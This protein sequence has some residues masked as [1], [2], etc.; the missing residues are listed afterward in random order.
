ML[1]PVF[2]AYTGMHTEFGLLSTLEDWL[3]CGLTVLVA[4]AGK[5][6]GTFVTA[7]LASVTTR[8]AASLG[9]LMNTSGLVELV[10]VMALITTIATTPILDFIHSRHS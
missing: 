6:G 5:F 4:A 2:F 10:V 7:K 1:L 3:F 8:D 9:I